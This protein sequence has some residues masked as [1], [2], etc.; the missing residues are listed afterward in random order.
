MA[1]S[2]PARVP[3]RNQLGVHHGCK[4]GAATTKTPDQSIFTDDKFVN[5]CDHAKPTFVRGL[6]PAVLFC[7]T[8]HSCR[9]TRTC[10]CPLFSDKY[11]D[12]GRCVPISIVCRG[13]WMYPG[14]SE[15]HK[16]GI[17]EDKS[18][19]NGLPALWVYQCAPLPLFYCKPHV[20]TPQSPP[21][22]VLFAIC[23]QWPTLDGDISLGIRRRNEY[24]SNLKEVT[25]KAPACHLQVPREALE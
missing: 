7:A 5:I 8:D 18:G 17:S 11:T 12:G 22:P 20:Q 1:T 15:A 6:D 24:I 23:M 2:S 3:L 9:T 25:K 10:S 16:T 14:K 19:P 21:H 13:S 4:L